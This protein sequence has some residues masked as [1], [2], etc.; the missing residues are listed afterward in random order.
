[1]NQPVYSSNYFSIVEQQ[2]KPKTK[3]F[4]VIDNHN[5][6]IAY[7]QWY[8]PWR[9]Y[10]LFPIGNTVWDSKCLFEINNFMDIINKKHKNKGDDTI[11]TNIKLEWNVLVYDFNKKQVKPFNIF[12]SDFVKSLSIYL[13][14]LN[15]PINLEDIKTYIDKWARY[16]YW[17]RTEFEINIS[18]MF[19][20]CQ[21]V[22]V[23]VYY[24]IKMNID[25]IL[26]YVVK[27]LK[28][29]YDK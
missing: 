3:V 8:A 6:R 1:M 7:I 21:S 27:E 24:Q 26:D 19:S 28:I 9:K 29:R 13:N 14:N 22:K 12:N 5:T 11:T 16:N 18:D 17:S 2:S 4:S 10:C 15:T 23:D 25:R 20:Q